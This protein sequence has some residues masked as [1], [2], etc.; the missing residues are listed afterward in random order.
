[1]N[2]DKNFLK[3]L[4]EL[5]VDYNV[6]DFQT[7]YLNIA[8]KNSIDLYIEY[9]TKRRDKRFKGVFHLV[10]NVKVLINGKFIPF[11]YVLHNE[12]KVKSK[13]KNF[14]SEIY[15]QN[16]IKYNYTDF[17]NSVNEKYG[18]RV[19]S[20]KFMTEKFKDKLIITKFSINESFMSHTQKQIF[21]DMI[22]ANEHNFISVL[23]N[24]YQGINIKKLHFNLYSFDVDYKTGGHFSELLILSE[25]ETEG[26]YF[27]KHN[28]NK[29][30]EVISFIKSRYIYDLL[31]KNH[32]ESI[33]SAKASIMSRNMSHNLGSHVM[34]YLKNELDSVET[35]VRKDTLKPLL[36]SIKINLLDQKSEKD[37]EKSILDILQ[38]LVKASQTTNDIELPFLVGM[39][40]F[41]N[42]LQE[43]QDY[44]ATVA[45][46]HIPSNST[47]SF[48]DFIYDELKPELRHKRHN[49]EDKPKGRKPKNILLDYIAASEG[50]NESQKIKLCFGEF[51][52]TKNDNTQEDF[53][54]L[55][56]LN[57]ALPGGIIGRQAFFS[58]IEN[59]IR[60]AAKHSIQKTEKEIKIVFDI[61]DF[62]KT[63]K[64]HFL[65][66]LVGINGSMDD[67]SS[68]VYG[69]Y[70]KKKNKYAVLSI[71]VR[72][73][74]QLS[75]INELRKGIASHYIDVETNSMNGDYKGIKEMRIS[76]A[77][78]RSYNIDTD[79][80]EDDAD[81]PPAVFVRGIVNP[82]NTETCFI[83]Y[84]ICLPKPKQVAV[85]F[86]K[87][88]K[89]LK[90]KWKE[91]LNK[92]GWSVN[93][94]EKFQNQSADYEL[95]IAQNENVMEFI[96]PYSP[97]RITC[98]E[99][100]SK[101]EEF[102]TFFNEEHAEEKEQ[103]K[104]EE[105]LKAYTEHY[106]EKW[107][108]EC[109]ETPL[110]ILS[111]RDEKALKNFKSKNH[112]LPD[113]IE[114]YDEHDK[115]ISDGE[116]RVIYAT[117]YNSL[118]ENSDR[119]YHKALFIDGVTGGN[120]TDRLLRHEKID[121]LWR[122]KHLG[123]ALS[124]VAIFDERIFQIVTPKNPEP[125]IDDLA[126]IFDIW[127]DI[128]LND[129]TCEEEAEKIWANDFKNIYKYPDEKN[130]DWTSKLEYY[131]SDEHRKEL[132]DGVTRIKGKKLYD[133]SEAERF[134]ER[135]VW[136]YDLLFYDAKQKIKIVGYNRKPGDKL[137]KPPAEAEVTVIGTISKS[138]DQ[139]RIHIYEPGLFEGF[140]F[141]LIHQGL[142]DKIYRLFSI[143]EAEQKKDFTKAFYSALSK[144]KPMKKGYLPKFIIHSGRSKPEKRD[145]PQN[146]PFIQFAALESA[147]RDCK[148][149]LVEQLLSAHYYTQE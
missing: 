149:T 7:A 23:T 80:Q 135:G 16:S 92:Y 59:I 1:M 35:I 39:G 64:E 20:I 65:E 113:K 98:L 140:D 105:T 141:L 47:V 145:M 83:Q 77:W 12:S 55:R 68:N 54:R 136:L 118:I 9:S 60:N 114:I 70:A 107:L 101:L 86:D 106:Y 63:T 25:N 4:Q 45:T 132:L 72:M 87:L 137:V 22:N 138:D 103:E 117:H 111:I 33:K 99:S 89:N 66:N 8:R 122:L 116:S 121:N 53:N 110:P 44:I 5:S 48:K 82:E 75:A 6:S 91:K 88:D 108:G 73:E 24:S 49:E 67:E 79:I 96:K 100:E 130:N 13:I 124:K 11:S 134:F 147:V 46:N 38:E 19:T 128:D 126:K 144:N 56:A 131:W 29:I 69:Y 139:Y 10:L 43:R 127:Y 41:I 112:I 57:I 81:E 61:I 129:E 90:K 3:E 52:G 17:I 27:Y 109:F 21:K 28:L 143:T 125:D 74:N 146:Q 119:K 62:D 15:N 85:V 2:K 78:L 71:T 133:I 40:R 123:A 93:Y 142:L 34:A 84:L 42:Y 104:V 50:Y 18:N 31:R 120:S 26:D 115:N 148:Y 102:T 97:S 58:I 30:Y 37:K 51:D 32:F 95:V 76:A 14:I 94:K 36:D